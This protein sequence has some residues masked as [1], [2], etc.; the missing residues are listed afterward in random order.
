MLFNKILPGF[1]SLFILSGSVSAQSIGIELRERYSGTANVAPSA[2]ALRTNADFSTSP[3]LAVAFQPNDTVQFYL[4]FKNTDAANPIPANSNATATFNVSSSLTNVTV[5]GAYDETYAPSN[6]ATSI[7]SGNTITAT[8]NG[9]L[10][11][12]GNRC[13]IVAEAKASNPTA[14]LGINSTVVLDPK[15]IPTASN[16]TNLGV[17][18]IV[19]QPPA[20]IC[21]ANNLYAL[22]RRS[23]ILL[24]ADLTTQPPSYTAFDIFQTADSINGLGVTKAGIFYGV[25]QFEN[26]PGVSGRAVYSYN[27]ATRTT[28]AFPFTDASVTGDFLG[29]AVRS[30]GVYFMAMVSSQNPDGTATLPIYAFNTNTNLYIGRIA[31]LIISFPAG[32]DPARSA[33]NGD[34]TFDS[35]GNLYFTSEYTLTTDTATDKG[36]LYQFDGPIPSTISS[37]TPTLT[38]GRILSTFSGVTPPNGAAFS[39]DGNLVLNSGVN[40]SGQNRETIVDPITGAVLSQPLVDFGGRGW[41]DLASCYLPGTISV[42]TRF[43]NRANVADNFQITLTPPAENGQPLQAQTSSSQSQASTTDAMGSSGSTYTL[44]QTRLDSGT[45]SYTTVYQCVDTLNN[46]VQVASGVG[47]TINYQ[48]PNPSANHAVECTF[49]NSSTPAATPFQDSGSSVEGV[50]RIVVPNIRAND[51]ADGVQATASN[52]AI[53]LDS[54][55]STLSATAAG[56]S[57]DVGSGAVSTVNT[58]PAGTYQLTYQLC[59]QSTPTV[60]STATI[61][62]VVAPRGSSAVDPQPDTGSA[63]GGIAATPIINVRVNDTVNGQPATVANSTI[64]VGTDSDTQAA[65][66]QGVVLDPSTGH[67]TTTATTP[68]G[69]YRMTYTLCDVANPTICQVTTV[70]VTVTAASG[71]GTAP[72]PTLSEFGLLVLSVALGTVGWQ[73]SRRKRR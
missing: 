50:G 32:A 23:N 43:A 39:S 53:T 59:L 35:A 67:V 27:P 30:D 71:K 34:I 7:V 10:A 14:S 70:T 31:N 17:T 9:S 57:V 55:A 56:I 47:T 12:T 69:T 33:Q 64:T 16:A 45:T 18:T 54:D 37:S 29:G 58:T 52:S 26:T 61:T 42:T 25:T 1:F 60:C 49:V 4:G 63:T 3:Y 65:A 21:S 72:I 13:I 62:V 28:T 41:V 24:R 20:A 40:A 48:Y 11:G 44:T 36:M 8:L 15:S 2:S 5:L 73:Q 51:F 22:A 19:S 46:N 6:C 66:A 68:A 38:A